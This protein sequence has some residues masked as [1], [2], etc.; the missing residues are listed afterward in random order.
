MVVFDPA[1]ILDQATYEEPNQG[2]VGIRYV[3]VNGEIAAENGKVMGVASG[4]VLRHGK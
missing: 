4:K 2:P 1:T 3:L